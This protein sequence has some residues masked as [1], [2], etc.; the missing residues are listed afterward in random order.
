MY[1]TAGGLPLNAND[2]VREEIVGHSKANSK[3]ACPMGTVLGHMLADSTTARTH[4]GQRYPNLQNFRVT[5]AEA[6][7]SIYSSS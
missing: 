6:H 4:R 1:Q 5:R 2:V 7:T 3:L